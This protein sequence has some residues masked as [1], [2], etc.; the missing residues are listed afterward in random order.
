MKALGVY[1]LLAFLISLPLDIL[2]LGYYIIIR[3]ELYL[4]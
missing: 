2:I 4:R 3:Y 1:L